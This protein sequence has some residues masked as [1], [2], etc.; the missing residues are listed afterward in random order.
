MEVKHPKLASPTLLRPPIVVVLGHVDHGKTTLL[1]S[2]RKS[3]VTAKETGGITQHIGAYQIEIPNPPSVTLRTGKPQIP[4]ELNKITFIDTPGHEAFA[5]MRSRG[6]QVADIAIL[7]VA[8]NDGVMPQTEEAIAHIKQEG[9]P[10]VVALNKI[11]LPE[12]DPQKVKQQLAKVGVLVEGFGGDVVL[13]PI[14]AKTGK[15]IKDLLEMILLI[16][17]LKELRGDPTSPLSGIVIEAK[18]DKHRGPVATVIV[19]NGKITLRQTVYAEGVPARVR[20]LTNDQ[21]DRLAEALPGAPVEVTGWQEVP[22]VGARVLTDSGSEAHL[23]APLVAPTPYSFTLPPL[24][25]E[26]K[27]ILILKTDVAGTL[28]AVKENLGKS[29]EFVS[30]ATGEINESDVLL[31]KST[32][33]LIIGFHVQPTSA[34]RKLGTVENVRIKTYT[35][36]YQ[37]LEEIHEVIELLKTPAAQEQALGE[38]VIIAQ[39]T[40]EHTKIAGCRIRSGRLARGDAVK[41]LR[42]NEVISHARIKSLRQG[43]EDASQAETGKECGLAFDKKLDFKVGD[44]IIAYK[45]HQLLA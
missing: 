6:A 37:L 19:K 12:V 38:A 5:K 44:R 11:D 8:A 14:S 32:G 29:V 2:I 43:K 42:E 4:K 10:Y 34:A 23:A 17:Q 18:L 13:V 40:V 15:G 31:A 9:I 26:A 22:A 33:A 16:A 27:V 36:I 39:F 30:S 28:E 3:N 7:V 21:G 45:M 35:T 25:Q 41:L 20:S 1:D 24:V